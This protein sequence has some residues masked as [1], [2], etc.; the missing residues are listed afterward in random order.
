MNL[1]P[2]IELLDSYGLWVTITIAIAFGIRAVWVW[3]RKQD[4]EVQFKIKSKH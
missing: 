1:A 3:F 4:I 2:W